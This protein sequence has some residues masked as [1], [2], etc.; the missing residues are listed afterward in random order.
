M[1]LLELL[2]PHP[3]HGDPY[4]VLTSAH[5]LVTS[6]RGAVWEELYARW[7]HYQG[8]LP[9]RN[10][11]LHQLSALTL[12]MSPPLAHRTAENCQ[13]AAAGASGSEAGPLLGVWGSSA[14]PAHVHLRAHCTLVGLHLVRHRQH[15]T[16]SHGLT[17]WLAAQLGRP[18]RQ[19]LQQQRPGRPLHQGQVRHSALLHL[20]QPH[21][22]G[23][24][25]CLSQ[26]QLRKDLLHLCH[27]HWL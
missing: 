7:F 15:G 25:Q 10:H 21:Q 5:R 6:V 2:F 8:A 23:L 19:A 16:A 4:F 9:G 18:D 22:R 20:Q 17:H 12:N 3:Q 26:H 27:A 1:V 24:W 13:A 11:L 14:L